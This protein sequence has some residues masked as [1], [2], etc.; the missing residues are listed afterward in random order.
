MA[1]SV[2]S[3]NLFS[4]LDAIRSWQLQ[5]VQYKFSVQVDMHK[6]LIIGQMHMFQYVQFVVL[7]WASTRFNLEGCDSQDCGAST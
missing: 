2:V 3:G 5:N 7:N 1:S 4:K 6:T